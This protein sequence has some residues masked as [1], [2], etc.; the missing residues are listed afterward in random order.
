MEE[1][2]ILVF[3]LVS[4][5]SQEDIPIGS[6]SAEIEINTITKE[7]ILHQKDI[8]S[9]E[10]YKEQAKD[11]LDSLM[12]AANLVGDLSPLELTSKHFYEA[13]GKLNATLQL[14]YGELEDLRKISFYTDT[15]GNLSYPYMEGYQYD[16]QTGRIDERY[17]R[18][19]ANTVV[20][21][22]MQ[23]KEL[24]F[25]GINSLLEDWKALEAEKYVDVSDIFSKK[26]FKK[27]RKFIFKKGDRQSFRNYDTNNPHYSFDDFDVYLATGDQRSV[28]EKDE[29]RPKDYTELVIGLNRG[30]TL[31]LAPHKSFNQATSI[32]EDGSVYA[33]QNTSDNIEGLKNRLSVIKRAIK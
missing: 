8:Y 11:G 33:S 14:R 6:K 21:F 28:F 13:E 23:R 20:K 18:F 22:K 16:L 19:D 24:R 7:V 30:F 29:L 12:R 3:A 2:K 4:F 26:D 27:L 25:D 10:Q 1:V 32:F 15:K 5:L 9:L 17:V 31:Y